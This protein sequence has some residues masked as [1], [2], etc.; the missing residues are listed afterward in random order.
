M[1]ERREHSPFPGI[2][3][4]IW[5]SSLRGMEQPVRSFKSFIRTAPPHPGPNSQKPL[6]AVPVSREQAN[7]LICPPSPTRASFQNCSIN[8]WKTPAAWDEPGTPEQEIQTSPSTTIRTY[9][10]LIP[11]PS[12]GPYDSEEPSPWPIPSKSPRQSYL[13]RISEQD[14]HMPSSSPRNASHEAPLHRPLSEAEHNLLGATPDLNTLAAQPTF[15]L[16]PS[17]SPPDKTSRADINQEAFSSL[18]I[19]SHEDIQSVNEHSLDQPEASDEH[20]P[21]LLLRGK[22]LQNLPQ[23]S[24]TLQKMTSDINMDEKLHELSVSQDYHNVLADQYQEAHADAFFSMYG[25]PE[26]EEPPRSPTAAKFRTQ[27]KHQQL[28]PRTSSWKKDSSSTSPGGTLSN[29]NDN[30]KSLPKRRKRYGKVADW[31]PFHQSSRTHRHSSLDGDHSESV[32]RTATPLHNEIH[33]SNLIPHMKG[34]RSNLHRTRMADVTIAGRVSPSVPPRPNSPYVSPPLEHPTSLLR[35]PG[36]LARVRPSPTPIHMSREAGTLDSPSLPN[37]P[38]STANSRYPEPDIHP[39]KRRPSSLYSQNSDE[40]I[41][42]AVPPKRLRSSTNSRH[43][44]QSASNPSSSPTSPLAHGVLFPRIPPPVPR[45]PHPNSTRASV[46]PRSI[47]TADDERADSATEDEPNRRGFHIL[48]RARDA[49]QA[50]KKHH[51]EA[52][53]EKLKKSIRV[54]GPT[55]PTGADSYVKSQSVSK[56]EDGVHGNRMPGYMDGGFI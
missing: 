11:E 2:Q 20:G 49:R 32:S 37:I 3:Q 14:D 13:E 38:Q 45:N 17:S 42:P 44:R 52:K 23:E 18:G 43:S 8:S 34:L 50:W 4:T 22:G 51:K 40:P 27:T 53:H 29:M 9:A 10:P 7:K 12:P 31:V 36:G 15:R 25:A 33:L 21:T 19:Q 16:A 46:P 30:G 28:M 24:S 35:L 6:P 55:D 5:Q 1:G 56:D 39:V 41:A 54:I 26:N 48:D 47:A